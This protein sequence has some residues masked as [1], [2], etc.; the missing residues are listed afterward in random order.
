[1]IIKN[2]TFARVK[3]RKFA[4]LQFTSKDLKQLWE[5]PR[6]TKIYW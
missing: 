5:I 1:M 6:K 2:I 3:S 4:N